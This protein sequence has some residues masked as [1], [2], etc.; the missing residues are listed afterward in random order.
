LRLTV[1]GCYG[2]YPAAGQNCSGYLLQDDEVNVLLDCGNG[3]LSRLRYFCQPWEL[4]AVILSHLHSDHLSD[5]MILRYALQMQEEQH[6][7]ALPLQV[8]APPQPE[9]E[10]NR[11]TY[12]QYLQSRPLSAGTALSFGSMRF[13]FIK[14]VHGVPNYVITVTAR[15]KKIVYSGDTEFFPGL[16][17]A[18]QGADLFLCEANYLKSD[19]Q[20]GKVNHLAA[21]QAAAVAKEA[22]VKRL[23]LTHHNPERDPRLALAEAQA[24]FPDTE[25]A[26]A[27]S[28]YYL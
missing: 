27:G 22:E 28:L 2:P 19:L 26:H 18:A 21:F 9:E 11:L 14:G 6:A 7:S 24:I 4:T 5:L 23:V 3:V 17:A 25:L 8:Y 12:K 10:Y 20:Q 13:T 15:G 1:L 16:T